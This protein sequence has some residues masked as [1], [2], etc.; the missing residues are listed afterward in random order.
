MT[1]T[2]TTSAGRVS[3][4]IVPNRKNV[5]NTKQ[6]R[7]LVPTVQNIFLIISEAHLPTYPNAEGFETF[8]DL[9]KI[10]KEFTF[11]VF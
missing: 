2:R 1:P 7:P 3:N 9:T 8:E 5:E 6:E 11:F 10:K 4:G